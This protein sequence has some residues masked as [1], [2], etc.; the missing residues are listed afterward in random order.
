MKAHWY[1]QVMGEIRGPIDPDDLRGFDLGNQLNR[2]S[3][4]RRDNGDWITADRIAGLFPTLESASSTQD[5]DLFYQ[6]MGEVCGPVSL[7]TLKRLANT[8]VINRDTFVREGEGD[9]TTADHVP[10]LFG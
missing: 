6:V 8:N 10:E 3:F 7:A 5:P 9:W 2:D 1:Y 4:V